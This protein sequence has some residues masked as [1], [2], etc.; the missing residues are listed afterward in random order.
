VGDNE[1]GPL[2]KFQKYANSPKILWKGW[3]MPANEALLTV[4]PEDDRSTARQAAL[5]IC[6]APV[7]DIFVK[8]SVKQ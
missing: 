3:T 1:G 5:G 2:A 4:Y 8:L 6:P 7:G